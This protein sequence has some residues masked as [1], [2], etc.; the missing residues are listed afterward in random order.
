MPNFS[1][2]AVY[3][4]LKDGQFYGYIHA[5]PDGT[6][7]YVG[8]GHGRRMLNFTK[9]NPHH[10][11][12][13]AKYGRENILMGKLDCSSEEISFEL[14]K[15]LIACLRRMNAPL[16]NRT[17]G[18]EGVT[19]FPLSKEHR[20]KIS[21]L[22]TGRPGRPRTPEALAKFRAT[23]LGYKPSEQAK[24][25]MRAA[26]LRK[27]PPSEETRA[28]LSAAGKNVSKESRLKRGASIRAYWVRKRL[29]AQQEVEKNA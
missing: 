2:V 29:A 15:G 24:A 17:G 28:K 11:N 27:A 9:R 22:M 18:G 23:R 19:G 16:V 1:G 3:T 12:V 26:A 21:A 6:P 20:A 10:K 4:P 8:K 5:K 14:E 13:V 7:F 25:N